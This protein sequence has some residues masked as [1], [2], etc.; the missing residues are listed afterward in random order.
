MEILHA[1][2]HLKKIQRIVGEFFRGGARGE[3]SVVEGFSAQTAEAGGDGGAR[4]F[5][6]Q[7]QLEQRSEAQAEAVAISFREVGPQHTVQEKSRFE[8][9]AGGGELAPTDAIPKIQSSTV[10]R[11][12]EEP[13]QTAAQ[14]GGL[15]DIG[16]GLRIGAAEEENGRGRWSG[17]EGF[18]VAGWIKLEALGQHGFIVV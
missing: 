3:R 5:V 18:G 1:A 14:V 15:A 12:A 9:G 7:V 6:F 13:V 11:R 10:F 16:L 8:S 2:A 17:G 4:I